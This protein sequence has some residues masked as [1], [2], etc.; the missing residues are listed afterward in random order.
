MGKLILALILVILAGGC[1]TEYYEEEGPYYRSQ[2][3]RIYYSSHYDTGILQIGMTEQD[4]TGTWGLPSQITKTAAGTETSEQWEYCDSYSPQSG[5]CEQ[6]KYL[7][8]DNGKL[9]GWKE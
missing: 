7:Y 6:F 5:T 9:T 2:P 1:I 8:F 4:I 3:Q